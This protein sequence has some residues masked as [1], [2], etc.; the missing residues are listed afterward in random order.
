VHETLSQRKGE[1]GETASQTDFKDIKDIFTHPFQLHAHGDVAVTLG[2]FT[3]SLLR[4]GASMGQLECVL[5]EEG[6]NSTTFNNS[7]EMIWSGSGSGSIADDAEVCIV[8]ENG[9]IIVTGSAYSNFVYSAR[10]SIEI[11][12]RGCLWFLRLLA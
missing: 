4:L 8:D 2:V 9:K 7:G 10:F 6:T 3:Y 12:T 1:N 11:Y 5:L